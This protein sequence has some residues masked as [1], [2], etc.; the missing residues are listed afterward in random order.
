ML[1]TIYLL[2][3]PL[4][5]LARIRR[6]LRPDGVLAVEF[7]GQA[8]TLARS[9]GP[10]AALIEGRWSRLRTDGRHLYFFTPSGMQELLARAGFTVRQWIPLP[11]PSR[12][13][14]YGLPIR[15]HYA[16]CRLAPV[17]HRFLNYC[18]K[19]LCVAAPAQRCARQPAV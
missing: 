10:A 18:P 12:P 19:L 15:L 6:F 17:S 13:G 5:A 4:A 1:D 8:Y 2:P 11:S 3:D 14:V 16:V 7:A 9:V